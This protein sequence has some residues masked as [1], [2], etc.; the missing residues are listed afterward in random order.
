MQKNISKELQNFKYFVHP[1]CIICRNNGTG[2]PNLLFTVDDKGIIKADFQCKQV[3]QGYPGL[4][5]GGIISTIM[6][7]AMT[8]CLF[9]KRVAGVT[10]R[11]S[12][13]FHK[14]VRTDGMGT[15]RAWILKESKQLYELKSEIW[16]DG[17]IRATSTAKFI[18]K[19]YSK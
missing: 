8:N 9:A 4:M 14:P 5:H 15:V 10:A 6:D 19:Q 11:L 17:I 12:I 7:A 13:K 3:F 16:Q 18:K 2:Y 1:N